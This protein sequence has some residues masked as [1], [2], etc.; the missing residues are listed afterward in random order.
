MSFFNIHLKFRPL[1]VAWTSLQ[2]GS[3]FG[4]KNIRLP[5]RIEIENLL[6][7]SPDTDAIV[8]DI[9][10]LYILDGLDLPAHIGIR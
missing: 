3:D 5:S 1:T 8:V 9:G 2:E 7:Y 6:C 10:D 4:P